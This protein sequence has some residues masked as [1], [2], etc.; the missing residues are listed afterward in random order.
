[1]DLFNLNRFYGALVIAGLRVHYGQ[2]FPGFLIF[3]RLI[4]RALLGE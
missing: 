2:Y 3:F 1:M 4:L